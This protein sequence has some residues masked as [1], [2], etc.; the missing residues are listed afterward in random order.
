ML[1]FKFL[2]RAALLS[3]LAI[4]ASSAGAQDAKLDEAL[5]D[6]LHSGGARAERV[7][8]R[9]RPGLRKQVRTLLEAHGDVVVAEHPSID[10]LAAVLPHEDLAAL[11]NDAA[12]ES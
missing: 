7:I 3:W 2:L 10:G 12:I 4:P 8:V 1:K 11:V 5:R 6:A 9:T